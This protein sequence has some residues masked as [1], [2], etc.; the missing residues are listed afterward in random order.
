MRG[1]SGVFSGP[2]SCAPGDCSLGRQSC[3]CAE[4][5]VIGYINSSA[6]ILQRLV[7]A[8]HSLICKY[9]PSAPQPLLGLHTYGHYA[10][11][12]VNEKSDF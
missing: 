5:H 9:S 7:T 1:G 3:C 2:A 11:S 6:I 8:S 4:V 10:L 12:N